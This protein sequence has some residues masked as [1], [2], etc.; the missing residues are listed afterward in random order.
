M[1]GFCSK[2]ESFAWIFKRSERLIF[3]EAMVMI[4]FNIHK[5]EK[6]FLRKYKDLK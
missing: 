5:M 6:L 3:S 4:D 2:T 1:L